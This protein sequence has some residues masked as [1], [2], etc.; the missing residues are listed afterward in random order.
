MMIDIDTVN[1]I[2]KIG[3][4]VPMVMSFI[5]AH[6]IVLGFDDRTSYKAVSV[7]N[8]MPENMWKIGE[9][10]QGLCFLC[11][12]PRCRAPRIEGRGP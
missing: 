11:R 9:R 10:Q 1:K 2:K 12:V 8:P 7:F 5:G 6:L 3:Y 4:I